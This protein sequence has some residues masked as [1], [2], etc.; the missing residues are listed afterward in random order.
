M[1]ERPRNYG[2]EAQRAAEAHLA[3]CNEAMFAYEDGDESVESPAIAPYCGCD[4][5]IVREVLFAAWSVMDAW[6]D[7]A[8]AGDVGS[9]QEDQPGS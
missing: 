1:S 4:T 8:L 7:D 6:V 5:C 3:A 9:E 2:E